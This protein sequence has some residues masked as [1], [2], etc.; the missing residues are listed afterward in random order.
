MRLFFILAA[1]LLPLAAMAQGVWE[2]PDAGNGE[3][4]E[5]QEE[6]PNPDA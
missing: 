4:K 3:A 5:Q 2:R 6:K 1:C